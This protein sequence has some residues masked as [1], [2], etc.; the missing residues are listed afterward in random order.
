MMAAAVSPTVVGEKPAMRFSTLP[1]IDGYDVVCDMTGHT[2]A[3]RDSLRSANGVC[4][5]LNQATLGGPKAIIR[6]LGVRDND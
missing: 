6:A 3:H 4:Q 5:R 1:T 2:V